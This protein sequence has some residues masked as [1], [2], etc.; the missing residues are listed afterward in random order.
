MRPTAHQVILDLLSGPHWFAPHEI[1]L[2]LQL[3]G[4]YVSES[5]CT[6]RCR[7]LRK[8]RFGAHHLVKR[9]R[10]DVGYYEYRVEVEQSKAA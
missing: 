7:D 6:A 2:Q 8:V 5:A 1:R 3:Q 10:K 4:H 9:L